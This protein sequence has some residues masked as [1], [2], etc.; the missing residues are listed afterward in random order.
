[1]LTIRMT[2]TLRSHAALYAQAKEEGQANLFVTLAREV[3]W[4]AEPP[5]IADGDRAYVAKSWDKV[6]RS[7][8]LGTRAFAEINHADNQE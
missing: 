1:M 5:Q 7:A 2:M 3:L 8:M 4:R 6:R